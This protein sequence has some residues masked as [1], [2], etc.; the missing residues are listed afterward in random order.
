MERTSLQLRYWSCTS[1]MLQHC[2][3]CVKKWNGF[4]NSFTYTL[5]RMLLLVYQHMHRPTRL[6]THIERQI[7]YYYV[8]RTSLQTITITIVAKKKHMITI[9]PNLFIV[10]ALTHSAVSSSIFVEMLNINVIFPKTPRIFRFYEKY[11]RSSPKIVNSS[12]KIL[13]FVEI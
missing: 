12:G 8:R 13:R 7:T 3:G 5:N 6:L 10:L 1:F 2:V 9:I 4:G 11:G